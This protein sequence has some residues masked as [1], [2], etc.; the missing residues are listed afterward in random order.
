MSLLDE[1]EKEPYRF[2]F[3][4]AIRR[5]DCEQPNKPQTGQSVRVADDSVRFGQEAS[6]AFAPATFQS[7]ERHESRPPRLIQR[8]LGLFG[9]QGP[10]PTHLTEYVRE[11]IRN[12]DDH[13]LQRFAD[14]FHHRIVSFFYRAW[15]RVRPTVSFDKRGADRF[16]DYVGSLFGL[17][18]KS[19]ERR[20][21]LPDLAKRHF[22]GLFGCQTHHAEGLLAIL[23]GYFRLPVQ[24]QEFIGQWIELPKD[25]RCLLGESSARLGVET[26]V[27]SHVW[28][29]QQK[30]RIIFGPLGLSDYYRMLPGGTQLASGASADGKN[31][32]QA[33]DPTP[34]RGSDRFATGRL[35]E[36]EARGGRAAAQS[37]ASSKL[38]VRG[39]ANRQLGAG[40]AALS[41]VGDK[42]TGHN[43]ADKQARPGATL[44][45]GASGQSGVSLDRLKGAVRFYVG[46][47][48]QWDLQLI[49]KKEETPPLGLGVVGRLGWSSWLIRDHMQFDPD[50]LVLDAMRV[51]DNVESVGFARIRRWNHRI[52]GQTPEGDYIL[53]T[54]D[55]E[56]FDR[57]QEAQSI[58][59]ATSGPM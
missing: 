12:H 8:F 54:I 44:S 56:A 5:L 25:C 10:L 48:L 46:D 32:G 42:L 23:R 19:L 28:D 29:C 43:V 18:M 20:D 35:T 37:G 4:H 58:Y 38:G 24:M 30:F 57:F 13:T 26:T 49:L 9:P 47:E 14:I 11:R 22:A 45:G 50:D 16:G 40:G 53:T 41:G 21:A 34:G 6:L 1:L 52:L 51:P 59:D 33:W 2:D 36:K 31:D 27:G 55:S 39:V 3:F 7:V 17:G 15:A